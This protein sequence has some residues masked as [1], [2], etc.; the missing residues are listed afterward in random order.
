MNVMYVSVMPVI[1]VQESSMTL[2][3]VQFSLKKAE[4]YGTNNKDR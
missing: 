4:I 1:I 2:L 3:D